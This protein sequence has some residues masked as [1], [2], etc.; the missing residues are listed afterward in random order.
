MK[1]P[2]VGLPSTLADGNCAYAD[3]IDT[4]ICGQPATVHVVGRS[5]AWGWV[6]LNTCEAHHQIAAASCVEICDMHHAAGCPGEHFAPAGG[7]NA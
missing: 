4:E 3:D 7:A 2:F 5:A 6:C 1:P